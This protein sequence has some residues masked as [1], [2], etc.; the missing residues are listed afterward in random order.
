VAEKKDVIRETDATA[1]RLAKTLLRTA[2][3]GAIAVIEPGTG[4]PHA[5]RVGVAT[6]LDGSPLTLISGLSAHTGALLADPRC[7]LMVGEPGKG[8]ALAH[9]RLS[10]TCH[11]R[12]LE[13]GTAE[14]ATA[15]RRYLNRNPKAK[16]YAGLGDFSFFRL[17]V[18]RA[19]LNGGFGK[20]YLLD[21]ADLLVEG[22]VTEALGKT[23]QGALDHMNA[24]HRD[25]I[26]AY[27]R[28][29]AKAVGEGW[30]LAGIDAD[31]IDLLSGDEARRVF[32][33][34]PLATAEDLRRTLVEMAR[35]ARV[36]MATA[37]GVVAD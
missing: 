33:P 14:H 37:T 31:G 29:Y 4:A 18:E 12:R 25:A 32:F 27:A 6:D 21:R 3:F 28:H 22:P 5:S 36:G 10:L 1:V 20:A 13:R 26:E 30:T 19:S 2:R 34:Q 7:S 17:E 23:E 15:E 35:A 8:D 24:D 11:A 9:P 16:L